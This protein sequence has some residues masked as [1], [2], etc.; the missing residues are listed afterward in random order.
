MVLSDRSRGSASRQAAIRLARGA[1]DGLAAQLALE[2][3]E[4]DRRYDALA[5]DWARFFEAKQRCG[6]EDVA[7][8]A[9]REEALR[10][11][12]EIRESA[13]REAQETLG[14]V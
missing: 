5:A 9:Q 6:P 4:L 7:L 12:K 8:Q 1:L 10:L 14:P 2:E 11:A 3:A 13:E